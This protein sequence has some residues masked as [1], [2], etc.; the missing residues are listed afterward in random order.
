MHKN[1]VFHCIFLRPLSS[2]LHKTLR[3]NR[4]LVSKAKGGLI[5]A[6]PP[7][8]ED[9]KQK[10]IRAHPKGKIDPKSHFE[11]PKAKRKD[12]RSVCSLCI[13]TYF[14]GGFLLHVVCVH[15]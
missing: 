13:R 8:T 6:L 12:V 7:C 3:S 1:A 2:K 5:D 14:G 11:A 15:A 4:C 9:L 10:I